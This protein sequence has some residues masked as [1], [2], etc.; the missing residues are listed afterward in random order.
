MLGHTLF[1][2]EFRDN[3]KDGIYRPENVVANSF[4]AEILMPSRAIL[5]LAGSKGFRTD[6][7]LA[8]LFNVSIEAILWKLVNLGIIS[9][10]H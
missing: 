2:N 1:G 5:S 7:D 9:N 8:V 6:Y 4:A 3:F 10:G